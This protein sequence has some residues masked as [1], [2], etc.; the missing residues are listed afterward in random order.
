M[1]HEATLEAE[2]NVV[3]VMSMMM[4]VIVVVVV[5]VVEVVVA[6]V[7]IVLYRYKRTLYFSVSLRCKISDATSLRNV[8][9]R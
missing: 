3:V 7:L 4:V 1:S 5:I 2:K 9:L 6:V 8:E